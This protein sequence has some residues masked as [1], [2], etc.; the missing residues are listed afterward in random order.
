MDD[1]VIP[2]TGSVLDQRTC[3]ALLAT[4]RVGRLV[5][6]GD[7]P[8]VTPVRYSVSEDHVDVVCLD[9][10]VPAGQLGDRVLL[11]VDGIDRERE[12]GWSVLVHGRLVASPSPGEL[13]VTTVALTGRWVRGS[14][15]TPPLDERGYL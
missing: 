6:A 4:A 9:G 2:A 13:A 11:E 7:T 1:E 12:A 10:S 15:H 3:T 14:H 8:M 5:V